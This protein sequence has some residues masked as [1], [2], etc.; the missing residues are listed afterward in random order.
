M[1]FPIVIPLLLA[2]GALLVAAKSSGRAKLGTYEYAAVM[3]LQG[4]NPDAIRAAARALDAKYHAEASELQV[5]AQRS[6][7]TKLGGNVA[8]V[9]TVSIT[10]L[11]RSNE[12]WIARLLNFVKDRTRLE[13]W[14]QAYERA[15]LIKAA[16][17]LRTPT[18]IPSL[19][20]ATDAEPKDW[21]KIV[22]NAVATGNPKLMEGV[23]VELEK[24]GLTAEAAALRLVIKQL[25][26]PV[27]AGATPVVV[28]QAATP[29]MQPLPGMTVTSPGWPQVTPTIPTPTTS[30]KYV[31]AAALNTYLISFVAALRANKVKRYS[32]DKVRVKEFQIQEN[33]KVDGLYGPQ[34]ATAVASYNIVPAT[35][36]YW[37]RVGTAAA[38]TAY[39]A[40]LTAHAAAETD[41]TQK[42]AWLYA[43]KKVTV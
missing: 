14:S 21:Q 8:Q 1:A 29:V 31:K 43:A 12:E 15:G 4:E 24:A 42:M 23:A 33:L 19:A 36:L 5:T 30:P 35:P 17:A 40:M 27:P 41:A 7:A 28:T 38:Q 6:A 37:P 32:E 20:P 25:G 34:T 13:A 10:G 22:S 18:L 3:G 16:A 26:G 9:P 11:S 39:K 2:G